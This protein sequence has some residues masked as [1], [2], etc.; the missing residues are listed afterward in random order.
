MRNLPNFQE[1]N[2][3]VCVCVYISNSTS[4]SLSLY[5][6]SISLSTY[7]LSNLFIFYPIF[8]YLT[9]PNN[10]SPRLP[11]S[12]PVSWTS[13]SS[14]YHALSNMFWCINCIHENVLK[15]GNCLTFHSR[16]LL[17]QHSFPP[18]LHIISI[19]LKWL[20]HISQVLKNSHLDK[21]THFKP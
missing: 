15:L 13:I 7:H 3:C 8:L 12:S 11:A 10:S 4:L 1:R 9:W 20:H 2:V 14:S 17:P 5:F 18:L 19:A 21:K 16:L 6:I